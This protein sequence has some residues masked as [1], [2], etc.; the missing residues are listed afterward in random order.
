[1]HHGRTAAYTLFAILSVIV[2][3]LSGRMAQH[4]KGWFFFFDNDDNQVDAF[5]YSD[6]LKSSVSA[7]VAWSAIAFVYFV[8][9]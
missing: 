4:A 8:V 9:L 2:L 7:V 1:V 3:G 6:S 5:T